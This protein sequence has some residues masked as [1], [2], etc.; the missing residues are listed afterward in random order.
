MKKKI[1]YNI[2]RLLE[3]LLY[4]ALG[5]YILLNIK[6][7][8]GVQIRLGV[9]LI[10]ESFIELVFFIIFGE[11]KEPVNL[12]YLGFAL[13]GMLLGFLYFGDKFNLEH[14]SVSWG[15]FELIKGVFGSIK[16][17]YCFVDN[18]RFSN[19]VFLLLAIATIVLGLLLALEK[20]E[21]L[22]IHLLFV[23]ISLFITSAVKILTVYENFKN[24]KDE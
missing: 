8:E 12:P 16:S 14:L 3:V 10:I 22:H 17:V 7:I 15:I 13:V 4:V 19:I 24:G 5:V 1:I 2:A 23:S 21:H 9:V 18:R 6:N 11:Y 20:T